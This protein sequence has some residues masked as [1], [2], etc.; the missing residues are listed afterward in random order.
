MCVTQT[1]T[2]TSLIPGTPVLKVVPP[3][4]VEPYLRGQRAVIAGYI[5]RAQ[6]CQFGEP[7]GYHNALALGYDGSDFAPDLSEVVVLRWPALD[8][9]GS[10]LPPP[11]SSH[12][13]VASVPEFYTL[14]V[15]IPVGTEMYR[16]TAS[17]EDFIARYDGQV[18]LRPVRRT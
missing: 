2:S 15:P 8:M 18:W 12:D 16:I 11:Q 9:R 14:P 6:D 1:G 7:I 13:P 5:Y 3:R 4:M 10:L 17:G